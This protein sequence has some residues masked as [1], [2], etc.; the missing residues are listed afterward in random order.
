MQP[1]KKIL[2]RAAGFGGGFA[3]VA[4]I[5]LGTIMWWTNRPVKPKPMNAYVITGKFSG[6][7]I[8]VREETMYLT[9]TYGLHNTTD[10]DYMLPSQGELMVVNP[11]NKGLDTF[12]GIMWDSTSRIPPGQTVNLKFDVPYPLSLYNTKAAELTDFKALVKFTQKRL[13]EI[14][15]FKSFDYS[16]RYEIDLPKWPTS[17]ETP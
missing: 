4:A 15:G 14:D 9:V 3:I 2:L 17:L 12:A 10:R 1:W 6:M 7:T 16:E 13:K 5:I 11:E 8:Q